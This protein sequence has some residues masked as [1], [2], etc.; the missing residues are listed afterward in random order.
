MYTYL[1]VK[2]DEIQ[3]FLKEHYETLTAPSDD[4]WEE[5]VLPNSTYYLIM[6]DR[7]MGFLALSDENIL[8]QFYISSFDESEVFKHA[9]DFFFIDEAWVSTYDPIFYTLCSVNKKA[10]TVISCLYREDE[11][12]DILAPMEGLRFKWA[13]ERDWDKIIDYH[14]KNC[15]LDM[16]VEEHLKH[17]VEHEGLLLL[18]NHD[19]MIGTGE[20]R[21]SKSN[22]HVANV[23]MTVAETYRNKGIGSYILNYIK[24]VCHT[25]GYTTICASEVENLSSQRAIEKVGYR[26]YHKILKIWF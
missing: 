14:R 6:T 11:K 19:K 5:S 18:Y 1:Q 7:P 9:L 23:G 25:K 26:C 16:W 3:S 12:V 4:L 24:G 20:Y 17:L 13:K 21:L 15:L 22:H 2:V 8:T 10:S